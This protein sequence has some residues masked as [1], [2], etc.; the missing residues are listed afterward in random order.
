M[1][2]LLVKRSAQATIFGSFGMPLHTEVKCAIVIDDRFDYAVVCSC[3][4]A[5]RPRINNGL[6]MMTVHDA[7]AEFA[8]D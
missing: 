6:S 2:N 1:N 4:C 7:F 3:N 8:A 5:H